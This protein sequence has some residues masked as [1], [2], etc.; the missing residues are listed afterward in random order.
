[1]DHENSPLEYDYD[2]APVTGTMPIIAEGMS[3]L[4]EWTEMRRETLPGLADDPLTA[5]FSD[6]DLEPIRAALPVEFDEDF[7]AV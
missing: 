1:M 2:S 6:L 5:T 7:W 4:E 3:S